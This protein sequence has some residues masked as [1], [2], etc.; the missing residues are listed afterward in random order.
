MNNELPKI[1]SL[2]CQVFRREIC[3]SSRVTGQSKFNSFSKTV[4]LFWGW[5]LQIYSSSNSIRDLVG[6]GE[7]DFQPGSI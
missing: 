3:F 6:A 1:G 5:F 2:S 4:P 7:K